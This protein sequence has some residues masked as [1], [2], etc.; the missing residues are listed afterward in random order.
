MLLMLWWGL[1]I[2]EGRGMVRC[3]VITYPEDI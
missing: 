1:E 2:F 3:I